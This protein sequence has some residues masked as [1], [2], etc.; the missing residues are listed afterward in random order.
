MSVLMALVSVV[1]VPVA[2]ASG[3]VVQAGGG[4]FSD[5]DGSVH[6]AGLDALAV[7]GY[8]AGTECGPG[9]ICPGRVL[10][11]WE[12][13]VWLGRALSD[14][15][16]DAGAASRF[17]DV[18]AVEWWAP[19]V[20]RL[21]DLGIT[22]GCRT[23][24]LRF[25][26]DGSVTRAQM[27]T[28]LRWAFELGDAPLQGFADTVGNFHA[29][30]IDAL[31]A[32]GVTAGC[33]TDPLRFCPDDSVTRAQMATFLARA[34]GLVPA[35]S[36]KTLIV[37]ETHSRV[38]PFACRRT[39][40]AAISGTAARRTNPTAATTLT[41]YVSGDLTDS[42][43]D[44][45]TDAAETK[46]GFDPHD[47]ASFPSEVAVVRLEQYPI[48][49]SAIGAY[50]EVLPDEIRI[51]WAK[52]DRS[53][54]ALSLR[55]ADSDEWNIYYGGHSLESASVSLSA[56]SLS[57]NETLIGQFM[58]YGD[59]KSWLR[60]YSQFVIDLSTID[61]PSID[62]VVAEVG[63]PSN[64]V[65]YTFSD[66]F[67]EDAEFQYREFLKR[68]FPILYEYLGPPAGTFN[69]LFQL[70]RSGFVTLDDGRL[71][72]VDGSFVPRLIV[73]ELAHAWKG[74]FSITADENWDY[75]DAL[76]G[77][78]EGLAEGIAFEIVREYVRSYPTHA[79]SI[80]LLEFRPYQ[81]WPDGA[82]YYDTV[83]HIR[84]TGGGDFWTP[85]GLADLRYSIA[86]TTVQMMLIKDSSFMT[87]FMARYY[88]T[89]R[90]DHSWR[91]NRDDVIEMWEEIVPELNG[92]PLGKYLDTVLVFNG[93]ELDE[94]VYI[95][96]AIRSYGTI[97][98]QQFAVSYALSDGRLW[99]GIGSSEIELLES[100]PYWVPIV[101]DDDGYHYIDTHGSDFVV[102][103]VDA[104]GR[105]QIRKEYKT[106]YHDQPNES[107]GGFGWYYAEELK[108]EKF[109]FGLYKETV[110]FLDYID[111]DKGARESFY[112]FGLKDLQQEKEDYVII[113]G[114]DGVPEG[115]AEIVIDGT[116][117][118]SPITNG[119]AVFKSS[120]WPFDLKGEISI[121]I[122]NTASKCHTYYR[123]LTEAATFHDY[124][125]HQFKIV[126]K[127]FNGVEDQFE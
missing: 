98:D 46:Y 84:S 47:T 62:N 117:Y 23:N 18:D 119:A 88:E 52:P 42:D 82:T 44:G 31:A 12:M 63:N 85:P 45:M 22:A 7:R 8:L 38:A 109:P 74:Q 118:V 89:I 125:Q 53:S 80:Q 123:V 66:D 48:S 95:L 11:R 50:Y 20:E 120:E 55:T 69:I 39:T 25:C 24:P 15:E 36:S 73:H 64:R 110:T 32:A 106:N 124:F 2:A 126:D 104:Y 96:S 108:M 26:P 94:G 29:A 75:D 67:P 87:E 17:A 49:G 91:P 71:I 93:R 4:A 6:E 41:R 81:Y 21:A 68:V 60:N 16:P 27:A 100:V 33:G 115:V 9:Q 40:P 103:V 70:G 83:K 34:L 3:V 99:W 122:T 92:Y 51:R 19:Y 112:F 79:A 111:H 56:L 28:V 58:E 37:E 105:L 107:V 72:L 43:G 61:I 86:A 90:D 121:T 10:K 102:E 77:F 30:N 13:A 127:D 57:G 65:S 59:D 76:S 35:P 101:L 78:E 54:Y 5:D 1:L 14:G 114:V 116:P 113:I 97:G